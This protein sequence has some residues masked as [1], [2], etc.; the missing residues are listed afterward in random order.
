MNTFF[1]VRLGIGEGQEWKQEDQ[2]RDL[3]IRMRNDGNFSEKSS[4]NYSQIPYSWSTQ[5]G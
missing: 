5:T 1:I 2:L 3:A 4:T